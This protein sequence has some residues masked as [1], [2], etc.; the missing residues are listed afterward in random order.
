MASYKVIQDIEAEDKLIGPFGIR[1]FIYLIIVFVSFFIGFKL[2]EVAWFLAL[3]LLPHTLFFGLL[4][5]PFGGQQSTE[6]WLLAKIRFAM[7]PRVRVWNQDGIQ[8]LVTITAPKKIEKVLTKNLTEGEVLS[9]L[10][11]LANTIDSRGWAIKNVNVNMFNQPAYA[12]AATGSDRLVEIDTD[13]PQVPSYDVNLTDDMLDEQNNPRV[14]NIDRMISASSQ[15]H[16]DKVV[17]NMRNPQPTPPQATPEPVA[18][19]TQSTPPADYWFLNPGAGPT[20]TPTDSNLVTPDPNAVQ[21]S[22]GLPLTP[23]GQPSGPLTEEELLDK[24]HTEK[25]KAPKSYGNMKVIKTLEEQENEAESATTQSTQQTPEPP[26]T[27]APDPD[28]LGLANNDD[29][30]VETIARQANKKAKEQD[31][32]VVINLH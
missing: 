15:A 5:L 11:A 26:M 7:K 28:I 8:E 18:P 17:Q 30:N 1:Q 2:A 21:K 25:D 24:L 16:R 31:G 4:A 32:E 27:P 6:T 10:E 3:P 12:G 13:T 29:L 23:V 22:Q 14:Q 20:T 19:Q 9:R